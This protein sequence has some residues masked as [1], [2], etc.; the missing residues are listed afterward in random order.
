MGGDRATTA[1]VL[2]AAIGLAALWASGPPE[3]AARD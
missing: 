1:L 3:H 2:A